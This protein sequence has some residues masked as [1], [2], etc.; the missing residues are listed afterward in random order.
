MTRPSLLHRRV[1]TGRR[2]GCSNDRELTY[3]GEHFLSR[4][5]KSSRSLQSAFDEAKRTVTAQEL[6]EGFTPSQPQIYI[7]KDM[8][9]YLSKMSDVIGP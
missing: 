2:F 6:S 3:F 8:E 5:L 4:A 9:A 7:G 1:T